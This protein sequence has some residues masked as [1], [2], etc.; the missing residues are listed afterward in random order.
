MATSVV[1]RRQYD[2]RASRLVTNVM[3]SFILLDKDIVSAGFLAFYGKLPAVTTPQEHFKWDVDAFLEVQDTLD[4]AVSSTTQTTIQVDNPTRWIGGQLWINKRTGEIIYVK[5]VN[6]ATSQLSVTRAA[7]ALNSSGGTAAAN[8]NDEDVMVKL[9]SVVGEENFRQTTHTVTP[10]EVSNYTQAMR[11]ELAM[12]RRQI[13]RAFESGGSEFSYQEMKR[14]LE[15][16]KELNGVFLAGEK[17]RFTDSSQGDLTTTAGLRSVISTYTWGVG[18]VLHEYAWDD[19]LVKKGFKMGGRRKMM[20]ASSNVILALTEMTKD[21]MTYAFASLGGKKGEIGLQVMSY[22]APN[23]GN[24]M[25]L[26][27]RFLTDNFQG[28]AY[29]VDMPQLDRMVFSGNGLSGDL[30]IVGN[31]QDKD[32]MGRTDTLQCDMGLRYGDEAGHAKITGV[33]GGAKGRAVS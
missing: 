3:D 1:G 33:T 9:G 30:E 23:G 21:R 31:T 19:F 24:L 32:D 14:L 8:M 29:I 15:A 7:T 4:G 16:R 12:S 25:I 11:W 20:F 13:K 27:D 22:L 18:G 28:E 5:S 17:S 2:V 6:A 26:E 10:T